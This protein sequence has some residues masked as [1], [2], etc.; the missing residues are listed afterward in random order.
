[1]DSPLLLARYGY[2]RG[3]FVELDEHPSLRWET[4][5]WEWLAR[6]RPGLYAWTRLSLQ[7]D[8]RTRPD[9]PLAL[10]S[11]S[12]TGAPRGAE[13]TWSRVEAPAGEGYFIAGDAAA[14]V[15]PASSQGVL[16]ALMQG[17]MSAHLITTCVK[18]RV[19]ETEATRYYRGWVRDLYQRTASALREQYASVPGAR[20]WGASSSNWS[21]SRTSW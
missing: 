2:V 8:P 5:G 3:R 10:S 14:V 13:V 17:M 19:P 20:A 11:G 16:R 21:D 7:G 6:V 15:D 1:V 18:G 9:V 4:D 12:A